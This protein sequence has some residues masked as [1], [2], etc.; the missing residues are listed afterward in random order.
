MS[1]SHWGP[2]TFPMSTKNFSKIQELFKTRFA[3]RVE[4]EQPLAPYLAYEVGGPAEIL[5]FPKDESDLDWIAKTARQHQIAITIVGTGTNLL[6]VDAGIRGIVISLSKAF[7]NIDIIEQSPTETLIEVG[8]GVHKPDLLHWSIANNLTGLEFS[9]GVPGTLGGGIYMNAGTKY[10]SYG[11][12]L[13]ELRVFDFRDGGKTLLRSE[14]EFGY[15]EQ[16]AV[17]DTIVTTMRFALTPGDGA[18]VQA[19]MNRIIAERAANQPL[20]FPSCGSTFKNPPGLSAG[21]LIERAGL[22]GTVVGGAEISLK[23]ANFILNKN[24]AKAQDILDLIEIIKQR[25]TEHAGV[26]LECEV[27][28]LGPKGRIQL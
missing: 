8:A 22:K 16:T 20:D 2:E 5:V 24:K 21:R 15:R 27:I 17:R 23:H 18:T 28:T 10:G 19:E 14:V 12:I 26:S 11:D 6:V 13:R 3:D 25:V 1:Y 7:T 9:S 4:F